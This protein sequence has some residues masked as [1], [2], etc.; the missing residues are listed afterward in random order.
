MRPV[1]RI[2][3]AGPVSAY[4]TY[5]VVSPPDRAVRTAC[6]EAGCLAWRHGWE[7][8]VDEST[9]LGRAQADYIRTRSGRTFREQRTAEGLTVFRFEPGQRCFA[10]HSTRPEIFSVRGGDWRRDLGLIRRHQRG[11]DWVEDFAEHQDRLSR[12]IEKG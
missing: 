10:E 4:V 5:R 7:T 11:Q 2:Q 3:P 9:D 12:A 1:T 8:R 6:E